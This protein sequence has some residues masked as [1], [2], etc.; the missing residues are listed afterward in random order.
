MKVRCANDA[1]SQLE[2]FVKKFYEFGKDWLKSTATMFERIE[3][4]REKFIW[5]DWVQ[6]S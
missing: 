3:V 2:L 1:S 6:A 4:E 5:N